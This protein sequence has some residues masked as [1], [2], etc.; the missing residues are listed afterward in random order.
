MWATCPILV[1][2]YVL[3]GFSLPPADETPEE[4]LRTRMITEA[5][6]PIDGQPVSAAEYAQLQE[7]LQDVND[8]ESVDS[9]LAQ[10]IFLLQVRR[11][12]RPILPF[13]P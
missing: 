4:I 6:S 12:V 8:V 11:V 1:S 13:I 2:G 10:L 7:Q 3:P 5:R 9:E